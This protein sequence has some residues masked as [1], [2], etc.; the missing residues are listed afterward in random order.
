MTSTDILHQIV[1]AEHKAQEIYNEALR[2]KEGFSAFLDE[3]RETLRKEYYQRADEAIAK[4]R[5]ELE[6][7]ADRQI[8]ELDGKLEAEL[9]SARAA[10]AA[11]KDRYVAQIFNM[12]VGRNAESPQ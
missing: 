3:R 7:S 6:A 1:E 8:A 12:V 5:K 9:N 2:L 4:A 11:N 10:F